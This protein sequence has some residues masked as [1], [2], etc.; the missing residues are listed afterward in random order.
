MAPHLTLPAPTQPTRQSSCLHLHLHL[1]LPEFEV[2]KT[3]THLG[4]HTR[5]MPPPSPDRSSSTS[6]LTSAMDDQQTGHQARRTSAPQRAKIACRHCNSRR[7]KCDVSQN[8]P[9]RN[10]KARGATC[11]VIESRRGKYPRSRENRHTSAGVVND[12]PELDL[13]ALP[14]RT[15]ASHLQ[16]SPDVS[17]NRNHNSFVVIQDSPHDRMNSG[18]DRSQVEE[19]SEMLFARMAETSPEQQRSESY[20]DSGRT[21]YLG[22]AFSLAFVVKTVC[23]PSGDT[24]EARVHYPIPGSVDDSARNVFHQKELIPEEVALLQAKGA[25]EL[26][27]KHVSEKLLLAFF[28]SFYP[29]Y[30]VFDRRDIAALY[31]QG[32]LSFLVHQT[33]YFI[34]STV[35]EEELL[36]EA[37]FDD[38]HQARATFYLRAKAL[39]DSDQE[40]DKVKLTAVLFLFGFWWQ[41]PED[42]KD[43]W[44]WLGAAIS[45]AQT[46]GMH[47]STGRSGLSP[48]HRSLW[49][50]IWWSIYVR[51]RHAA[52]ALGRPPRIQDDDCDVELLEVSDFDMEETNHPHI[53]AASRRYHTLYMME[54]SKLAILL[55]KV[56]KTEYSA[57]RHSTPSTP[58][59]SETLTLELNSWQQ[60]IPPELACSELD[61]TLGA[62]FWARMLYASFNNCQILFHRPRCINVESAA[63]RK[64]DSFARAAADATTRIA[65][66]LLSAGTLRHGQLH[67]RVI[68]CPVLIRD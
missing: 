25:Y 46:L 43:T 30:Q 45:L 64:R 39:Y 54:M 18:E 1:S 34:A 42:Q 44:H 9:C 38:R 21:F 58:S 51:D 55:G 2:C 29:A 66:D 24:T 17:G 22:E 5:S 23:S 36:H 13:S 50:R 63:A 14:R 59:Y 60:Q 28:E 27:P 68:S 8:Q 4:F 20:R 61:S 19:G 67:L 41:G 31:E 26:P 57:S 65:E 6:T 7:V 10:C 3:P 56:L 37:G 62:S 32:S 35:C 40:R 49:K 48:T 16:V 47:R 33:I 11:Q 15:S 53:F 12:D 52:A